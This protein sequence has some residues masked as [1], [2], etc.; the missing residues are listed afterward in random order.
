MWTILFMRCSLEEIAGA[1]SRPGISVL[2]DEGLLA[3]EVGREI[4]H[5]LGLEVHDLARHDRILAL[6]VLV[7]LERGLEVVGILAGEVGEFRA[8]AHAVGAMARGAG[9]GQ[10]AADFGVA[11]SAGRGEREGEKREGDN[12]FRHGGAHFF[13][14]AGAAAGAGAAEAVVAASPPEYLATACMSACRR[15]AAMV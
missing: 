4:R 14:A 15:A 9:R 7:V 2:D 8:H 13:S 10:L 5:G 11:G 12:F 6:A 3:G 1:S